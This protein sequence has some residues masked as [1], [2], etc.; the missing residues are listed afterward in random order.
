MSCYKFV[1]ILRLPRVLCLHLHR[2]VYGPY[3]LTKD[4]RCV[5]YVLRHHGDCGACLLAL[6]LCFCGNLWSRFG[7]TLDMSEF[8]GMPQSS[9]AAV[10]TEAHPRSCIATDVDSPPCHYSFNLMS[11]V[12]HI[13]HADGGHF[14]TYR[15]LPTPLDAADTGRGGTSGGV[16]VCAND[17]TVER[18]SQAEVLDTE[19]YMLFYLRAD[20]RADDLSVGSFGYGLGT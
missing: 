8:C 9:S 18:V 15:R 7:T 20:L 19:A 5:R 13:G 11:V 17:S 10:A 2:R 6:K 1:T 4:S 12:R 14:V 16:W 3:G